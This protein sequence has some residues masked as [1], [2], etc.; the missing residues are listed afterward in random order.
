MG[1]VVGEWTFSTGTTPTPEDVVMQLRERTGLSI[2]CIQDATG[3]LESIEIA[4]IKESLFDWDAQ[5]DRLSV[6]SFVPPHPYLWTH[7]NIVMIEMGGKLSN[8]KYVWQP[9]PQFETLNRRWSEL[10]KFQ[11]FILS[12]PTINSWRPLDRLALSN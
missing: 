3:K 11:R 8:A 12:L 9:K 4:L 1:V 6:R 5:P 10:S 7:L 2:D